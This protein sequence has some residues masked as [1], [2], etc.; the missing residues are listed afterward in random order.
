MYTTLKRW[1]IG[2]P[3][4]SEQ[5]KEEKLPV[6]KALPILSSDALSSVAYGTEQ[7]LTVLVVA[8][9]MALWYSLPISGAIV[10]LLFL[11]ILSYR[12]VIDQY[13]GGGGAYIVSTDNIG[14][15][16]G[17]IAGA[18]LL[19]DYTLTVA[20]S[21]TAGAAAITSAVPILHNHAILLSVSFVLLIMILNLRGLRESGTIFAFPTYMFII[22]ILSMILVGTFN[23]LKGGIP[24]NV[25][26][27]TSHL[28]EGLTWFLLFR[29]FSSGCSALT[30]IE[31]ISNA[32]PTF[33]PPETKHAARTLA[34][35]GVLLATLFAGVSLLAYLYHLTPDP[36]QTIVSQIAEQTFGRTIPYY[37]VQATTALILILAANTSYS[38]FPL[39]ASI[40]AKDKLMPRMF[41]TRG[42]R[43]NFSN[44]II[45]LSIA[46]IVLILAF[47][48]DIDRLIPLYAIGVFTS[49]TLAQL[50][51]VRRWLK[52]KPTG[53][54]TK[55]AINATGAVVCFMVLLIFA[56]TKFDEGAWVIVLV[57]PMFIL[58][59]SQ[60]YRHYQGIA[61]ELRL[62]R[63][64]EKPVTQDQLLIIPV[65][66]VNRVVRNTISYA[67]SLEV[68]AVALY[69]AFEK[70]DQERMKNKW[71]EWDPGIPLKVTY[72]PYRSVIEPLLKFIDRMKA[73]NKN[74]QI[75]VLI[76]QFIPRRWWHNLLHNQTALMIRFILLWKKDVVIG[77]VPFHLKK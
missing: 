14:W 35:L 54:R 45:A 66:G 2:K 26:P 69:I 67:K 65:G 72:S 71:A 77:T 15:F 56:I 19:V 29:A 47:G 73:R 55:L 42:D 44:G 53:W 38:G 41:M 43:L 6:W 7:I 70:E 27:V 63:F 64:T 32:T 9:S 46:A 50:G 36:K 60:I 5:L 68:E 61:D 8:G 30:G 25:P 18:S 52:H 16:A 76:P 23:V 39:L 51:M 40:M 11:L 13:P 4:K 31:A 1:I 20:V 33:R 59:F 34:I 37:Y 75:T 62:D 48:G 28:P 12:Q 74:C 17:A 10:G 3:L 24:A 58:L 57:I 49:F 21:V 22:G